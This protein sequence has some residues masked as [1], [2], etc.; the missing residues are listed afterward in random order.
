MNDIIKEIDT[1]VNDEL[2]SDNRLKNIK[3]E[4]F[5]EQMLL[6]QDRLNTFIKCIETMTETDRYTFANRIQE[7]AA[8]SNNTNCATYMNI[9]NT[10]GSLHDR[11]CA[12]DSFVNVS[13]VMI[14]ILQSIE[15]HL[16]TF[17]QEKALN[18]YNVKLSH[19]VLFGIIDDA[20]TYAE[21]CSFLLDGINGELTTVNGKYREL[22]IQP[23]YRFEFLKTQKDNIIALMIDVIK[24]SG[25]YGYLSHIDD[26]KKADLPLVDNENKPNT[27]FMDP[28]RI[29]SPGM[30]LIKKG[31]SGIGIFRWL[32]EQWNLFRHASYLKAEKEKEWLEAH[33]AL[34]KLEL[35]N[36]DHND[37]R[38]RKLVK[39][40]ESYNEMITSVDRKIDEYKRN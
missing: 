28:R 16:G 4:A 22:G 18:I 2:A 39:I 36:V 21:Y 27:T 30:I 15:S 25:K 20:T 40:I 26:I 17:I 32:G 1:Y 12:F 34:L 9:V 33:V 29:S 3:P 7:A 19:I 24:K 23:K 5:K 6:L 31:L 8:L 14:Q 35:A 10:I 38:Y 11:K 13:N 37:E